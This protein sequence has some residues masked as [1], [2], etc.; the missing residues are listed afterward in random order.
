MSETD[1]ASY[2]DDSIDDA[3]KSPEDNS[4]KI[5]FRQPNE[6]KP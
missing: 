2:V 4:I 1:F 5:F 6:S 3:I